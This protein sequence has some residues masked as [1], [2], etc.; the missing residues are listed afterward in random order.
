MATEALHAD[1]HHQPQQLQQR[2]RG[3]TN[4]KLVNGAISVGGTNVVSIN[5]EYSVRRQVG[6]PLFTARFFFNLKKVG[7][8]KVIFAD[9]L[10]R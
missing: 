8:I 1:F 4:G 10:K 2:I 3:A 6:L 7:L 5:D 9:V